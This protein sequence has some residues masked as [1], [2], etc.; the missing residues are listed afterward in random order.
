M[1]RFQGIIAPILTPFEDDGRVAE[2]LWQTH[3]RWVLDQGAHYLAPFGTTGEALSLS[4]SARMAALASL[5]D[6]GIPAPSLMTGTGLTSLH[7]T[8]ALT[9]HAVDLGVAA[10][11]VLPPFFYLEASDDGHFRYFAAL[12]DG[13]GDDRLKICL[14]NIPQ[15]SGVPISPD[16]AARLNREFPDTFVAYKDSTGNWDNTLSIINA[17][18]ALAVFPGTEALMLQAMEHGGAGCISATVNLNARALRDVYDTKVS[19]GDTAA[20]NSAINRLRDMVQHAGLIRAMKSVLAVRYGDARWLNLR[21]PLL[22]ASMD[23]GHQVLA[24]LGPL[25]GHIVK[26]D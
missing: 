15:N 3:A 4:M 25:A 22:N 14:Y 19:G 6:A 20:G 12:V 1:A 16:L 17:A 24:E 10:V 5:I 9:R 13:V 21:P 7:D 18:P 23:L 11:M 26:P 2:D 8:L